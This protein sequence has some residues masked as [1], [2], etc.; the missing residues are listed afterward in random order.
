[1]YIVQLGNTNIWFSST[2]ACLKL[3]KCI[4]R[5]LPTAGQSEG[6]THSSPFSTM[7]AGQKQPEAHEGKQNGGFLQLSHDKRHGVPQS[8][9]SLPMGHTEP[10]SGTSTTEERVSVYVP[11]CS[12]NSPVMNKGRPGPE[13][14]HARCM[15]HINLVSVWIRLFGHCCSGT[16]VCIQFGNKMA[17]LVPRLSV[18]VQSNNLTDMR[19]WQAVAHLTYPDEPALQSSEPF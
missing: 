10:S 11:C 6:S 12:I 7:P 14:T 9:H 18:H 4:L 5:Y 15:E 19:V 3:N 1:M 2:C 13:W 8:F 16:I 17:H